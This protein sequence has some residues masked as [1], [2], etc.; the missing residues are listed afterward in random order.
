VP[1]AVR[2]SSG[3]L[4]VSALQYKLLCV[5]EVPDPSADL[6]RSISAVRT[7]T[8]TSRSGHWFVLI[9]F[10]MVTLGAMP[11]YLHSFPSSGTPGCRADRSGVICAFQATS[12]PL[13]QA[14]NPVGPMTTL[15][16]SATLYWVTA[17]LFGFAIIVAYYRRRA[18]SIG[19]RGRVWPAITAGIALL[20][21][22]AF[23]DRSGGAPIPDLW[24]RG[25][26][27]LMIIA[28]GLLVLALLERSRP[29]GVF[30]A[31]FVALAMLSVLYDDINMFARIGLGS[32]FQGSASELPNLVIPGI[33]LLLGG[34][35]FWLG[36]RRTIDTYPT[37]RSI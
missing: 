33:Y 19:V 2:K 22:V 30:T 14:F 15:S 16:Q 27:A 18:L 6:L 9:V 31:G 5:T 36:R 12:L 7:Q 34:F 35:G 1:P 11:F 26:G 20:A 28:I 21:L 3:D 4:T 29:F 25:T 32:A 10:G 13:G 37:R 17:I 8:R 23:V 24:V